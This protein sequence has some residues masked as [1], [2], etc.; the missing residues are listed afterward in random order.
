MKKSTILLFFTLTAA[1]FANA[2]DVTTSGNGV[3]YTLESLS[4][5]ENS[6]V[7][8][9][10]KVY[11]LTNSI[12]IAEGDRFEIES[13]ATMKMGDGVQLR[14]EGTAN[15]AATD[16]VLVTR[17]DE[18]AAPKGIY[19]V[20]DA[21]DTEF[22]NIDFEY[23]GL[24]NFSS[25]GL[26][27][28]N[29]TFRYNN[30][31]MT[32]TGALAIG[33]DG[34][35]FNVDNCTFEYNEVPAIGGSAM[36]ANGIEITNCKFI[37]NNTKNTNKPQVNLTVGGANSVS[38]EN[39]EFTGAQRTNVGAVAVANMA[40]IAGDNIVWISGNTIRD[41]RYGITFYGGMNAT[42]ANN[43][44]IDNK[45]ASS[46]MAGGAGISIYDYGTKPNVTITGNTIEG[47]LWGITVLGG[48]NV[49]IGKVDNPNAKDYN[50]GHNTFKNNGN[51][52]ALYDLYNN[53]ALTIYAQGNHWSV[54]EQTA[55]KIESVIFH[56]PDDTKL[57]E[58]IYTPAWDGEGSVNEIASEAIRYADGKVYAEG[59]D[60][61]VYTLG[62]ALV[63][64]ANSVADLS[65]LASGVYVARANGKVLKCVK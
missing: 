56:K 31:K 53:S 17:A 11:T 61:Q 22:K 65:A 13:G 25:T 50:P 33:S 38:I 48:E 43:Q 47:N 42:V 2:E 36:A 5:T 64:R 9:N 32:M 20:C 52:G 4:T 54:D 41:H 57:G 44:I 49:N 59:A 7:T 24:R 60:I 58:V 14:I 63:A 6:G 29:C 34:A 30:G 12:T 19:M 45:Y 16:R 1:G 8:K 18:N 55:E 28:A 37:D 39:C 3:T 27:V 51:G 21:S 10:G 15:F 23:A 40:G 35:T 62:G 26:T 46:A